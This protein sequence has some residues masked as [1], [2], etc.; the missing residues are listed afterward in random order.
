MRP[1][2]GRSPHRTRGW[3]LLSAAVLFL[4]CAEAHAET[5]VFTYL[6]TANGQE[7]GKRDAEIRYLPSDNGEVRL[8]QA[9]TE[10]SIPLTTGSYHFKQ[11]LGGRLGEARSFSSSID[12][13]GETREVQGYL[14]PQGEWVVTV[15]DKRGARTWNL[16]SGAA[17]MTS[18]EFMDPE[19]G[20]RILDS[21][22]N[23]KVLATETG[24]ILDGPVERLQSQ[25]MV[26]EGQQVLARRYRWSPPGGSMVFFYDDAGFLLGYEVDLVGRTVGAHLTAPPPQRDYGS[27]LELPLVQQSVQEEDL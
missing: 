26:F 16:E 24:A 10:F 27:A 25:E 6:L 5:R 21:V 18:L 13:N 8:F 7:I 15:V 1:P 9:L 20:K 4:F 14:S 17:D 22:T 23:L 3:W 19:Q 12:D 2:S 11:R